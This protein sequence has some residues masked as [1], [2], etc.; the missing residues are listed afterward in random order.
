MAGASNQTKRVTYLNANWSAG[1]ATTNGQ[2]ELLV[3]LEDGVRESVP[4]TAV[5]L[6]AITSLVRAQSVLLWDPEARTL[7]A[8]NLLGEWLQQDWKAGDARVSR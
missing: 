5:D 6:T 2:F 3:V 8:A 1:D 4:L 7:I